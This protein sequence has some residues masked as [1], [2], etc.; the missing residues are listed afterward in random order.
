VVV[1]R[2]FRHADVDKIKS[3]LTG[4]GRTKPDKADAKRPALIRSE[5]LAPAGLC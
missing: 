3:R 2:A 5:N 4:G 1:S